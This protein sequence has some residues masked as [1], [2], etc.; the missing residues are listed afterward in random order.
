VDSRVVGLDSHSVVIE[1]TEI[2]GAVG[3]LAALARSGAFVVGSPFFGR[4]IPAT[5]RVALTLALGFAFAQPIS[6]EPTTTALIGLIVI[7]T[8]VGLALGYLTGLLLSL[9]EYAGGILDFTSG[10]SAAQI[11]DPL[12]ASQTG[13]FARS[14]NLAAMALLFVV[15]G[16][17][18]LISALDATTIAIPLDGGLSIGTEAPGL[19]VTLVNRTI[20]LAIQLAL[21]AIGMLF[22]I[23]L[24]LGLASRLSPQSNVFIIGLPAKMLAAMGTVS[25]VFL[26]FPE[27]ISTVLRSFEDAVFVLVGGQ[28]GG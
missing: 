12:T 1:F 13:I 23:E 17:R 3:L 11:F 28:I 20:E 22:L 5:G 18:A 26:A 15:G 21:P 8:A 19:A 6:V 7:N 24:I 2:T 25:I 4:A 27:M 9:F 14:M 16:D 10:L